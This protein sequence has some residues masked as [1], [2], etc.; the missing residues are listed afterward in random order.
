M[1]TVLGP[2]SWELVA[3]LAS[4][5]ASGVPVLRDLLHPDRWLLWLGLLFIVSVYRFPVGIVGKLRLG[6]WTRA[7]ADANVKAKGVS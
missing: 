3:W 2:G 6:A 4:N 1:A 5:A 7:H